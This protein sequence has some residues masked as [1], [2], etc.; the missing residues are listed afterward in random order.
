MWKIGR[1]KVAIQSQYEQNRHENN[2][3]EVAATKQ[4]PFHGWS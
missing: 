3:S 2:P 4:V 1:D